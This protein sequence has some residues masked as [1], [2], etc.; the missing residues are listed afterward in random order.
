MISIQSSLNELDRAHQYRETLIDC[1]VNAVKNCAHYAI[2]F[3]EAAAGQYRKY[4]GTLA[5]EIAGGESVVLVESRSTLRNLLRDYREKASKYLASLRNELAGTARAL[6]EILD[7]LSQADG[8]HETRLRTTVK[9]LREIAAKPDAGHLGTILRD[10][11]ATI[12][13]SVE[14]MRKQHQV[15][16]SQFQTEIRMLHKRIDS[17]EAA[18]AID[19]LTQ[20]FNRGEMENRIRNGKPGV[21]LLMLIS[22]R[23]LRRAA[24]EY[25]DPIAAEL[26]GAFTRRLRNSLHPQTLLARWAEEEFVAM[27]DVKKADALATGKWITEHLSGSYACLNGGKTVRPTLHLNVGIVE[28]VEGESAE[29]VLQR[30]SIFLTGS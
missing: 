11:A 13:E 18:V 27:M 2:E 3:D 25:G 9:H 16:I 29:A 6:E 23:G 10:A 26:A 15:T 12:E 4:L 7:S 24:G 22:A 19:S 5:E 30:V 8:D 14:Q 20:L 1:Y 17:L 28:T 21:F